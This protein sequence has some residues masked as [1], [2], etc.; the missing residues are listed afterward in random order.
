MANVGE[1][2][3]PENELVR[4]VREAGIVGAGGAGFPT[5]IKLAAQVE[6]VIVNAAECE[7]LLDV[8]PQ[9]TCQQAERLVSVLGIVGEF[10]GAHN[11]VV[12]IKSKHE[13]A[14]AALNEA[15][16]GPRSARVHY[17][18]NHYPAGDEHVLVHEV[19]GRLV[20]EGGIPLQVGTVVNNVETLLNVG[21]ALDGQ[22]VTHKYLTIVGE[23]RQPITTRVP[24]GSLV[25]DVLELAGGPTVRDYAVIDGGPMMGN[26]M[27]G[28]DSPITKTTKAL[29]V[30]PRQSL[31][32]IKKGVNIASILR[33]AKATC[34]LCHQCTQLCPRYL[35]GHDL[36]PHRVMH[37]FGHNI[38]DEKVAT[39]AFLCCECG[40]CDIYACPMDLSPRWVCI[41]LKKRLT[42]AGVKNPHR[43]ADLTP[44]P[45]R[46]MRGVPVDRLLARLG[47]TEYD[48]PAPMTA[49]E[50]RPSLVRLPLKQHIGAP[51]RPVV[52]VGDRVG[53]GQVVGEIP[54]GAL[55][56]RVHASISGIV[57]EVGPSIVIERA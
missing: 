24:V 40:V 28:P 18:P 47:L 15:I 23:V 45:W 44:H 56:A 20:P 41:E 9:L 7:P 57:R 39:S 50:F 16:R 48:R 19:T 55:G 38:A 2:R 53:E 36:Q 35:L 51:A 31:P 30:L 5:H 6:Y 33:R 26:L 12:G 27:P 29:I 10:T 49:V 43:R 25:K 4:A 52:S 11:L 32:W 1:D 13:E 8:D 22:P 3:P 54:E 14:C 42:A 46:H 34:D 37:I 17:L 21:A